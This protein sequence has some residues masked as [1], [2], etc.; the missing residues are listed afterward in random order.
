MES[1]L[2]DRREEYARVFNDSYERVMNSPERSR[3]FYMEFYKLLIETSPEAARKFEHTDMN[4]Q[5]RSLRASVG[6]LMAYSQNGIRQ[7]HLFRLAE[8]HGPKGVDIQPE[9]Y[10]VWLNCLIDTVRAF[11]RRFNERV[12]DAWRFVFSKGIEFMI[13][14]ANGE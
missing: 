5:I 3:N 10:T 6:V 7:D 2:A 8:R 1:G 9:L 14:H 12:E 4:Q 11:D 13:A